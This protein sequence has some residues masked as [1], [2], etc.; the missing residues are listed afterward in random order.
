[1][2]DATMDLGS[3]GRAQV[4]GNLVSC[5]FPVIVNKFVISAYKVFL[6]IVKCAAIWYWYECFGGSGGGVG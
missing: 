3:T 1:M 5:G 6:A 4:S 2:I